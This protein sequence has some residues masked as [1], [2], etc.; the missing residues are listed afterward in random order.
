MEIKIERLVKLLF[1]LLTILCIVAFYSISN[2][3]KNQKTVFDLPVIEG[4]EIDK[5]RLKISDYEKKDEIEV[6][7]LKDKKTGKEFLFVYKQNE[8]V[9]IQPLN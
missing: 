1:I 8:L 7:I 9:T 4:I 6:F 5:K 2:K 3:S